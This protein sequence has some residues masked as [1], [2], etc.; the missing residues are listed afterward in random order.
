MP[1]S[2][3]RAEWT[4]FDSTPSLYELEKNNCR[5]WAINLISAGYVNNQIGWMMNTLLEKYHVLLKKIE[6]TYRDND[7][8]YLYNHL[9]WKLFT[10]KDQL[11]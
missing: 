11:V 8:V 1:I 2:G 9:E 3:R 10:P 5:W 7:P 4:Q 6:S